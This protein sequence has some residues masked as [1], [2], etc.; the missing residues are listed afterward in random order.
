MALLISKPSPS[1]AVAKY[2]R[3]AGFLLNESDKV[4]EIHL[5]GYIDEAKR[6]A[7]NEDGTPK[8]SQ[9]CVAGHRLTPEQWAGMFGPEAIDLPPKATLYEFLKT[10]PEWENAANS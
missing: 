2:W 9:L 4:L 8:F 3:I 7:T 1:G 10:L 5:L 6:R